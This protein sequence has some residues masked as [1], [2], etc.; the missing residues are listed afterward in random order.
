MPRTS[1][2]WG[3]DEPVE[4]AAIH[5]GVLAEMWLR[6][7]MVLAAELRPV[8]APLARLVRSSSWTPDVKHGALLLPVV[9]ASEAG[10]VLL[11]AVEA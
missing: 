11:V 6:L 10:W 8:D 9:L 3:A 7:L 5:A 1:S 4:R 2:A